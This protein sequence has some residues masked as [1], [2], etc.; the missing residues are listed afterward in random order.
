[1][2]RDGDV[3]SLHTI[4]RRAMLPAGNNHVSDLFEASI[5][6]GAHLRIE[7]AGNNA[8]ALEAAGE[9]FTEGQFEQMSHHGTPA[10]STKIRFRCQP[11]KPIERKCPSRRNEDG[12]YQWTAGRRT[13]PTA[14]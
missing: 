3:D 9:G 7:G 11:W 13:T 6:H 8:V 1:M 4:H 5:A 12:R 10:P 14:K 2:T